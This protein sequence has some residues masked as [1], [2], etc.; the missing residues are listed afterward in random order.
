MLTKTFAPCACLVLLMGCNQATTPQTPAVV[1]EAE[2]G[3]VF[4]AAL[5]A[6][7]SM[8]E[9]KMK[10][11]YAPDF[12]GFDFT[13]APLI[14]DRAEWDKVEDGYAAAKIDAL[15][16]SARKIQLLGPDAFVASFSAEATSTALPQNNG[17]F[18][19]NDVFHRDAA[20]AWLIVNE[21]CSVLPEAA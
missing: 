16:V 8:D 10:A 9:A 14:T 7:Q 5:S 17:P 4:D 1:S 6:W 12:V 15:N 21:H 11:L 19:C 2:A 3:E 13:L 20:G 18:R